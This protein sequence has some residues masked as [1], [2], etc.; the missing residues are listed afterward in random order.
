MAST[1]PQP[2]SAVPESQS[3]SAPTSAVLAPITVS[4]TPSIVILGGN[5][6]GLGVLH[7]LARHTIPALQCLSTEK[8]YKITLVTP[9]THFFFKPAS[10]RALIQPGLLPGGE[11]KIFRPLSDAVKQYGD[12][13]T[14]IQG[15]ATGVDTTTKEVKFKHVDTSSTGDGLF[16]P[17]D[18]TTESTIRFDVL[19]IA[20]GTKAR[21]ALWTLPAGPEVQA[22]KAA[23]DATKR[24][25]EGIRTKL[26]NL[27]SQSHPHHNILVAGGGPVGVETTGEIASLLK[28]EGKTEGVTITLLSGSDRLLNRN[29]NDNLGRKAE[30]YLKKNFG[31][32]V[33]VKHGL[34]VVSTSKSSSAPAAGFGEGSVEERQKE[35]LVQLSDGSTLTV[36]LYIDA[37]GGLGTADSFLPSTWLDSSSRVLTRDNSFRVRGPSS[38]SDP[39]ASGIYAVGDVVA[40]SDNTL[41]STNFQVPVVCSSVGVDLAAQILGPDKDAN[42][43]KLPAALKQKTYKNKLSG[44]LLV[45]IGPGGGV[46]QVMGWGVPSFLVK[47]A[48]AKGF[49]VDMVEPAVSGSQWK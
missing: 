8:Q 1:E 7:T 10:P 44:T 45:P 28:A 18:A 22:L 11:D 35:T 2:V 43:V 27:Q 15:F 30:I 19:I 36:G 9:N 46:G 48:K 26:K 39:A 14:I 47:V 41:I 12:L 40:G 21:S 3:A 5:H 49:L 34:K 31:E 4:N 37:T 6:A 33:E 17:P 25:W 24:E 13:V 42:G 32:L 23:E 16:V 20:T 38:P 29:C